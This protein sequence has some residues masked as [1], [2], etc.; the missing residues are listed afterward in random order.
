[1]KN[2]CTKDLQYAVNFLYHGKLKILQEDLDGFIS[3][4][5][6]LQL[7]GLTGYKKKL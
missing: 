5:E 7:K 2:I 3:L 6:E 1:M 4:T